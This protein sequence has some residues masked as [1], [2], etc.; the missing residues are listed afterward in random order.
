MPAH[1]LT[2]LGRLPSGKV[3]RS[4]LLPLLL[5]FA[6]HGELLH[7]LSHYAKPE[8]QQDGGK[9]HPQ[10]GHCHLCLAFAQVDSTAAPDAVAVHL[11]GD[12]SFLQATAALASDRTAERPA[13]RNRGPPTFL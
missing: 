7:E 10:A 12:L 4:L 6:Q 1:F 8:A 13:R 11:L 5:L 9:Q 3:C 2:W